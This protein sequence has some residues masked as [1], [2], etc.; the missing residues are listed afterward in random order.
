MTPY[1]EMTMPIENNKLAWSAEQKTRLA[2]WC[3]KHDGEKVIVR[4]SGRSWVEYWDYLDVLANHTGHTPHDLHRIFEAKFWPKRY[5]FLGDDEFL[6]PRPAS[7]M[8]FEVYFR[9]VK[10]LVNL[11]GLVVSA[12][13]ITKGSN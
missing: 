6:V 3:G 10:D 1:V 4:V 5:A 13:T 11:L 2:S 8:D 12:A 7:E 9:N